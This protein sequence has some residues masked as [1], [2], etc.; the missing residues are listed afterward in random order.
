MHGV[1]GRNNKWEKRKI[2]KNNGSFQ[3]KE[4]KEQIFT[5]MFWKR[6]FEEIF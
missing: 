6:N 3:R 1:T 4:K 2:N 5:K